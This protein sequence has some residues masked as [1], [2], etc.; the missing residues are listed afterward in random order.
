MSSLPVTVGAVAAFVVVGACGNEAPPTAPMSQALAQGTTLLPSERN[1]NAAAFVL[2]DPWKP[3]GRCRGSLIELEGEEI[4]AGTPE[5]PIWRF[6]V[7]VFT[8]NTNRKGSVLCTF[9]GIDGVGSAVGL[10]PVPVNGVV[11]MERPGLSGCDWMAEPASGPAFPTDAWLTYRV[12][13]PPA[14]G[15]FRHLT[16]GVYY[17]KKTAP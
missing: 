6:V 13:V 11:R 3:N 9:E 4:R 2:C 7:H 8:T 12:D 1:P 10:V 14:D 16:F 5:L 17:S 15:D